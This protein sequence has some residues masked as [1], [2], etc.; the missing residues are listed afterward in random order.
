MKEQRKKLIKESGI[1][2]TGGRRKSWHTTEIQKTQGGMKGQR[3]IESNR[4]K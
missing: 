3:K 1:V 4:I 2:G